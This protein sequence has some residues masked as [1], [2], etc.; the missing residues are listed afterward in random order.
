MEEHEHN[1]YVVVTFLHMWTSLHHLHCTLDADEVVQASLSLEGKAH[2]WW[3]SLLNTSCHNTW[4]KFDV[5]FK[6]EFLPKKEKNL[7]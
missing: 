5:A 3:M 2:K 6:K 1:K 7:S 4:V